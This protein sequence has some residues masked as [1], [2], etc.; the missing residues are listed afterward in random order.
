MRQCVTLGT[1]VL[2][3]AARMALGQ[4]GSLLGSVSADSLGK[5]PLAGADVTIPGLG[6]TTRAN[7]SGD[8][9]FL[10][11]PPGTYLVIARHVGLAPV[12]DSV[13]VAAERETIHDFVLSQNVVT[14]AAVE[15]T[16]KAPQRLT[17]VMRQFEDR[18]TRGVGHFLTPEDL[19]RRDNDRLS[20]ILR[21]V[22]G[23]MLV[24]FNGSMYLA[25]ARRGETVQP[26]RASKRVPN[27]PV[28]CWIAIYVDGLRI[29]QYGDDEVPDM[30][31]FEGREFE[32][33]E[34]YSG[35]AQIPPELNMT[36]NGCGVLMLWNR[37]R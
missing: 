22:P 36:G 15:A 35:A 5:H 18:R 12:G 11:L 26:V 13:V 25:A 20:M 3:F 33:I 14:L 17:P 23:T 27:A 21:T 9:R 2:A 6:K 8:Y 37:Q 7:F 30:D 16:A 19:R 34:F 29:Y 4:T 28:G 1:V 10:A 31:R 32:A 24:S